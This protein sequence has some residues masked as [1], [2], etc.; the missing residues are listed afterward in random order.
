MLPQG[1]AIEPRQGTSIRSAPG[2]RAEGP[3]HRPKAYP[4]VVAWLENA[5][6]CALACRRMF[7]GHRIHAPKY[8]LTAVGASTGRGRHGGCGAVVT[9]RPAAV[10]RGLATAFGLFVF[11]VIF[12]CLTSGCVQLSAPAKLRSTTGKRVTPASSH[13]TTQYIFEICRS[14]A[15]QF[16]IDRSRFLGRGVSEGEKFPW[17]ILPTCFGCTPVAL[18]FNGNSSQG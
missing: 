7:R 6:A 4:E 18:A 14:R 11:A 15:G 3:E 12:L 1:P 13:P 2:M 10:S 8:W 17:F 5:P 16:G 9:E